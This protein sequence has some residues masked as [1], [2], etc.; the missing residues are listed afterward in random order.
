MKQSIPLWQFCGFAASSLGGTLL[1]YLYDWSNQSIFAAPFSGVNESTW[2]H[3]KLLF[4]PLFLFALVQSRFFRE[5]R[6]F[7]AVKLAGTAAGLLLIPVLFYTY[8]GAFGRSP[9]W[10]NIAIF[11]VSAAVVYLLETRLF[12]RENTLSFSPTPAFVLLCLIGAAFVVF[13][14][15]APQIPLFEDPLTGTY[16]VIR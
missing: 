13:T 7:W 11:F 4:F 10:L 12:R 6:D 5:R 8:N 15:A 1:H 16:G 14:F 3:M 2:E 9:D